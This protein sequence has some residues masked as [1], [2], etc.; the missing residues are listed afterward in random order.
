MIRF[1]KDSRKYFD[2]WGAR[3]YIYSASDEDIYSMLYHYEVEDKKLYMDM[4]QFKKM[5]GTYIFSRMEIANKEEMGIVLKGI[6]QNEESP[7]VIYLYEV[8]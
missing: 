4:E 3:A 7:Y 6:Y 1:S 2:D 8:S 5:G